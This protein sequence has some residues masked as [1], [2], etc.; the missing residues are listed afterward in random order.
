M[1]QIA[2]PNESKD[3]EKNKRCDEC[4]EEFFPVHNFFLLRFLLSPATP[5]DFIAKQQT[6]VDLNFCC[7]T[8]TTP[9]S[10]RG[11]PMTAKK[12]PLL[13]AA[14][15]GRAKEQHPHRRQDFSP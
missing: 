9:E 12:P 11:V 2:V 1:H 5:V 4:N 10:L 6:D 8:E 15:R 13:D 7:S 14:V 3:E